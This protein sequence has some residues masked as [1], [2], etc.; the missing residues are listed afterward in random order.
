MYVF[1]KNL[2]KIEAH[3]KDYEAGI[4]SYKLSI[5]QFA[6]MLQ[7]EFLKLLTYNSVKQSLIKNVS[8][9]IPNDT[10]VPKA[11]NWV[12]NGAVTPVKNQLACGSC[13]SFTAVCT[14]LL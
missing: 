8:F 10:E 1:Q 12:K 14:I 2:E 6:D 4:V 13:W 11:I 9:Q 5:S 3:N 7:E